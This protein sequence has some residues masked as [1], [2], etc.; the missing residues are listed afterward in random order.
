MPIKQK[1]IRSPRHTRNYLRVYAPY[2][3]LLLILGFGLFLSLGGSFSKQEKQVLGVASDINVRSLLKETNKERTSHKLERLTDN[4]LLD[5]AAQTKAEDMAKQNYWSHKTPDGKEPWVFIDKT[6]YKYYK[7][8]ENLAYGFNSSNSTVA[9]WMNSTEHRENILD[10]DFSEVGFGIANSNNFQGQGPE[11]IVVAMYGK[12]A[13]IKATVSA[14][15]NETPD[16]AS[17]ISYIQALTGGRAPWSGFVAGILIGGLIVYLL[18]ARAKF[19]RRFLRI[20]ERFIVKHPLLDMT[21]L[22]LL[23]LIVI[24]SQTA[25]FIY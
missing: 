3:P 6:G 20:S 19:I 7:I 22:A 25:G 15:N 13:P 4:T 21:I 18:I 8:A 10:K 5:R 14:Q 9:G 2:I 12:P 16:S 23:A 24:L 11:T 1:Q 17:K